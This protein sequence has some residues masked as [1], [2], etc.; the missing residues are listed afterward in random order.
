V[1]NLGTQQAVGASEMWVRGSWTAFFPTL[2]CWSV[3]HSIRLLAGCSCH[4]G[5]KNRYSWAPS[6]LCLY[7]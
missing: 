7:T 5:R 6:N 2:W 1:A 4:P 3:R